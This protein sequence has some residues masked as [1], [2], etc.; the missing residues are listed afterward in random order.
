MAHLQLH[1]D[2]EMCWDDKWERRRQKYNLPPLY[3]EKVRRRLATR[4]GYRL[5]EDSAP[6]PAPAPTH[7]P[8]LSPSGRTLSTATLEEKTAV[9]VQQQVVE[10]DADPEDKEE[11]LARFRRI[12]RTVVMLSKAVT[13]ENEEEEK[14]KKPN[15][16]S[17]AEFQY[18]IESMMNKSGPAFDPS[19]YKARKE[20]FVS[21]EAK[22]ILRLAPEDRTEEQI[23]LA[24]KSVRSAVEVF[25]EFPIKMQESLIRVGWYECFDPKRVI[26]RQGHIAENFYF[27]LSG[28]AVVTV[29]SR[30]EDTGEPSLKT[31]AFLKKGNSFGELALMHQS[32]RNA[33]VICKDTVSLLAVGREDFVSIFMHGA[34]KPDGQE[35]EH[36]RFLRKVPELQGWPVDKLPQHNPDVCLYTFFRRGL[37]I[38]KDSSLADKI[39]VV[40]TGRC[41]VLKSLRPTT[42]QFSSRRRRNVPTDFTGP[43]LSPRSVASSASDDSEETAPVSSPS[44]SS[45]PLRAYTYPGPSRRRQAR[46]AT[47]PSTDSPGLPPIYMKTPMAGLPEDASSHKQQLEELFNERLTISQAKRRSALPTSER[48]TPDLSHQDDTISD[49]PGD[50]EIFIQVQTLKEGDVFGLVNVVFSPTEGG[51][52][53]SL[54]S[55]G[56]ECI[57]IS[58]KFFEKHLDLDIR[59]KIR[60]TVSINIVCD[61]GIQPYPSERSLQQKLQDKVNWE[62]FKTRTVQDFVASKELVSFL[63]N[64]VHS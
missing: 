8:P 31:V 61:R 13:T 21:D 27:I 56:A 16:K 30:D 1:E 48:T 50:S 43:S 44:R 58:R 9:P 10:D 41:R 25:S 63:Q 26:I 54:V 51:T 53:M 24:L 33:S 5:R 11:P 37:V 17:F 20:V 34:D 55:D 64:P 39:Y 2:V 14:Q 18:E 42:P 12:T 52:G 23:Q 35:P 46:S 36:V 15:L 60:S 59:R 4:Y 28:T 22:G 47:R 7:L 62:D 40:V 38:C 49:S 3:M 6:A 57:L 29:I 19:Y 45:D 32:K